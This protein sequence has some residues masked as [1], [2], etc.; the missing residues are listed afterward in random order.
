MTDTIES[1][2]EAID[3]QLATDLVETAPGRWDGAHRARRPADGLT[4]TVLETAVAAELSE[5][6]GYDSTSRSGV[7]AGTPATGLGLRRCSP[8]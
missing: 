5:H 7:T 4:K 1:M 6:L 2:A 8:R 3:H